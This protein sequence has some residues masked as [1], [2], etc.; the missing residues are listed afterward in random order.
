LKKT[1][2]VAWAKGL[3]KAGYA[4]DPRYA[5]KIIALIENVDLNQYDK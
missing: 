2:Y 4:T 1:D 5:E 3:K